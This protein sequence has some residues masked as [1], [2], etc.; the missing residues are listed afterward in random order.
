MK[1]VEGIKELADGVTEVTWED[2]D[3]TDEYGNA[4]IYSVKEVNADGN[5]FVP[6]R[7]RKSE[8]GL[9]VVNT[10][11]PTGGG[12]D[13]K[14]PTDKPTNPDKPEEPNKPVEPTVPVDPTVPVEP[15]TP[16][17]PDA[18]AKGSI[19]INKVDEK[20]MALPGAEFTLYDENNSAI[21]TAVSDKDGKVMFENL[22][23]GKYFVRETKAPENYAHVDTP[24]EVTVIGGNSYSYKFRNVPEGLLIQDPDVP[25]GWEDI[26]DPDVP[27]GTLPNTGHP[28]NTW[29]LGFIGLSLILAGVVLNKKRKFID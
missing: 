16:V 13:T 12:E 26:S 1:K 11:R 24:L 3:K 10:K 29:M 19:L 14:P 28:L 4:Y 5:D 9:T 22:E 2:L 15:I 6:S 27:T 25:M 23:D 7:Y 8:D 18:S 17:E 20:S 21:G